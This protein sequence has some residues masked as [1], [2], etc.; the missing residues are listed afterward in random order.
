[1]GPRL[2]HRRNHR[3]AQLPGSTGRPAG[4]VSRAP[5]RDQCDGPARDQTC[6]RPAQEALEPPVDKGA[7]TQ[8][9]R[10]ARDSG[11]TGEAQTPQCGHP[12]RPVLGRQAGRYTV[13][14]IFLGWIG[15]VLQLSPYSRAA[16]QIGIG[17]FILVT[18]AM[19][20]NL[21]PIFRYFII[22]PPRFVTRFIRR[23]AK[24]NASTVAT[25]LFLGTLTIFIPC[26]VTQAMMVLAV[27]TGSPLLGAAIMFA[28]ILGTTPVFFA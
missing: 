19:L 26:G 28:F 15:S 20:F 9:A 25:P 17:I 14:G 5:G 10:G 16:L 1:S 7:A 4:H 13:L 24:N 22:E 18:A 21:H 6:G 23:Y 27:G 8:R 11:A 3:W 2:R 12:N